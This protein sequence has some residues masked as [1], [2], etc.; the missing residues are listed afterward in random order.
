MV[1][2]STTSLEL[3]YDPYDHEIIRNPHSL[4]RRMRE[5]GRLY[6]SDRHAF[7][8]VSRFD[9]IEGILLN[10]EVF[11]S[12][13]GVTLDILKSGMEIPKGTLIFEDPPS[14]TIHRALLSRM[15]TARR[16]AS[17]EPDIRRLCQTLLDPFVGA[18]G[19]DFV[20]D[21]GSQVPMR[22]ISMLVGIPE[23]DQE[24]VRDHFR[25]QRAR[26]G[27]GDR[28]ALSGN[29]FAEYIDWRAEHPSD[30]I[31]S[32]LLYSEFEDETGE[33]R[34]LTRE[35][36]LAYINIVAAAGNETTRVLIGW[37]GKLLAENPD[38]RRLLV[39]TPSLASNA[40]EE[41]LRFEPNTLQNCRYTDRDIELC[42]QVVPEG[43]VV[44]TLT[45]SGNRDERHFADP[46]R[47]DVT[48]SMDRHLSF[49]FGAHYCLGQALARLEGRI[50]LEEV[51]ERFPAWDVDD[52]RTEFIYYPDMRGY[53][54]LPVVT[55]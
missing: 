21:F 11:V 1:Y 23:S 27:A 28:D 16:V 44:A 22:V 24:S 30:D 36:L 47:F 51:L 9:D 45:P 55:S 46:D 29:I 8:A 37:T 38:Q 6:Y 32:Q 19:F 10:R 5:A 13:K 7:Y 33:K 25:D 15:F 49:G 34:R 53:G 3:D 42:G 54:S 35:E 12:R 17:L 14:H 20:A 50:A 2:V 43:S 4:F 39:E 41:V 40:I 18:G 48:R 26:E 31:M 52:A